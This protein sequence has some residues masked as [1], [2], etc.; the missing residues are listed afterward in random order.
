MT[1]PLGCVYVAKWLFSLPSF[2]TSRSSY[3]TLELTLGHVAY[4]QTSEVASTSYLQVGQLGHNDSF[5]QPD[6]GPS[7]S[8]QNKSST[9]QQ[10]HD[11]VVLFYC[12]A[13]PH[14]VLHHSVHGG[15]W[16]DRTLDKVAC[17]KYW[18]V[19]LPHP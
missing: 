5:P 18:R 9:P 19:L 15:L 3:L 12:T 4:V 14:T 11:S 17:L 16:E 1:L 6:L 13:W 10:S 2:V 7:T 8:E